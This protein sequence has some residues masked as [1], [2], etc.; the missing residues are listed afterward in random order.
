MEQERDRA[1]EA[2]T[3]LGQKLRQTQ[4]Q[5]EAE[6][7]RATGLQRQLDDARAATDR[8]RERADAAEAHL[9][10]FTAALAAGGFRPDAPGMTGMTGGD[11]PRRVGG[12]R[13]PRSAVNRTL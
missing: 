10:A 3:A 5:T 4:Q 9:A 1:A 12:P 7:Q 6:E 2:L 8:E 13:V 11:R